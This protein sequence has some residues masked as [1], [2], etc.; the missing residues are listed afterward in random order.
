MGRE[1]QEG[2]DAG[3]DLV[4]GVTSDL[5][6]VGPCGLS[7]TDQRQQQDTSDRSHLL[8]ITQS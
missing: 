7:E 2:L 4:T 5:V 1:V 6:G 8:N 3:G